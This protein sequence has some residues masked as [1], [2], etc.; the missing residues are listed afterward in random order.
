MQSRSISFLSCAFLLA[1]ALSAAS[2]PRDDKGSALRGLVSRIGHLL[3]AA[4]ACPNVARP[5][6]KSISDK[7]TGVIK[8]SAAGEDE[9]KAVTDLFNTN[10]LEGGRAVTTKQIDCATA[11][12]ELADLESASAPAPQMNA[13][14]PAPSAAFATQVAAGPIHGVSD[15]E[16]RFGI[17]APFSGPARELGQQMRVGIETA[18]RMANE[19]GG[20]NGR[21]L[22]LVT[23][24][25][26][27]EPSR[28][29]DAMKQLYDQDQVF[30]FIGNVGTPTAV[31]AAPFA[32]EHRALFYGAFTGTSIL[33]NDPPDRYVFNY[34]A[35]YVEETDAVVRYLVKVRRLRPEQIAV[36]AQQDSYGDAGFSGVSKA[37]RTLKGGDGGFILR[38]GYPRNTVDVDTAISQLKANKTP[39]KAV[40]MVATY[41]AAAKFIEKTKDAIPGLTYTNVSF[42][43]STALRDELMLLGPRYAQGVIVT[44]VVPAVDG[45]SSL[46]LE[47]KNAL[48]K[49]FG[50]E[51]PDYVSLEG[52]VSAKLLVEALKRAGPQLDTEHVVDALEEMHDYDM[53]LG[54]AITFSRSEH[55]GSHR[56]WGTLLTEVGK[57]EPFE[58]Q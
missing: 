17:S 45:Y 19:T 38:V 25:D 21:Y 26:G 28:T 6:I 23:A 48:A 50:G 57:Y 55:Q 42:V 53:G 40:V 12:R 49:Y 5:R 37:M 33:R 8:S 56:V 15:S 36:F 10:Y 54:T 7:I 41:R 20:V 43:G 34:R 47:Y 31:V 4:S 11:D 3:G 30:G 22:K 2:A 58:L 16:I 35:S 29:A 44:Q 13:M 52:Y 1:G 39:I 27:Y 32:L 9:S 51:A 18:F 24:D 46:I 14:T